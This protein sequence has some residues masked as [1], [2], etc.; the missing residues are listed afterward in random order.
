MENKLN[1]SIQTGAMTLVLLVDNYRSQVIALLLKNGVVVPNGTSNEEIANKTA[2]L[3]RISKSF[4]ND[5]NVFIQNPKVL[6][7][8]S[9]GFAKNAQYFRASG[10]NF[11][12]K[13]SGNAQYFRASGFMNST[14]GEDGFT[15]T[16][17]PVPTTTPEPTKTGFWSGLSLQD[18]LTKG[19]STFVTLDTNKTN[20][21]IADARVKV[22]SDVGS[23]LD[24]NSGSSGDSFESGSAGGGTNT[25]KV[26]V[27]SLVGVALIGTVVYFVMKNK[28]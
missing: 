7:T 18:L 6:K 20:R 22:G 25:T 16:G 23:D 17:V 5:L 4:A 3:L 14:G 8:L 13:K 24:S 1:Q 27:L 12:G 2:N 28:K 15:D 19:V 11:A 10:N 26:V 9:D 21:A